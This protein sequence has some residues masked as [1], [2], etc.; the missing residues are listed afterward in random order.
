M[1]ERTLSWKELLDKHWG[2]GAN[3]M[4]PSLLTVTK[5][6]NNASEKKAGDVD[7]HHSREESIKSPGEM[8]EGR[9]NAGAM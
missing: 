1:E 2:S 8:W 3:G 4:A 6:D 7:V 5:E 9:K